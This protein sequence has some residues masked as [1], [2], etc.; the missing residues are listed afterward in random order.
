MAGFLGALMPGL[1]ALSGPSI[2]AMPAPVSTPVPEQA[3]ARTAQAYGWPS[4][5]DASHLPLVSRD[6]VT[7]ALQHFG[8]TPTFLDWFLQ[9]IDVREDASLPAGAAGYIGSSRPEQRGYVYMSP[10]PGDRG[11]DFTLQHEAEHAWQDAGDGVP[12]QNTEEA[13][14]ALQGLTQGTHPL[15]QA[16]ANRILTDHRN[17]AGFGA[18]T[19]HYL[20]DLLDYDPHLLPDAYTQRWLGFTNKNPGHRIDNTD[21][22]IPG[23]AADATIPPDIAGV[24]D[25]SHN[26][27]GGGP[28]VPPF[29]PFIPGSS[30][31]A[32][33]AGQNAPGGAVPWDAFKPPAGY[34]R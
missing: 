27:F 3:M 6:R 30:N 13:I 7:G 17:E 25:P 14:A 4:P 10:K 21:Q 29:N 16:V 26:P 33:S 9:N 34:K 11:W 22:I 2:N 15:V 32:D 1:E 12:G 31:P 8:W 19:N 23:W 28:Y 20:L 18:H 24:P 5:E